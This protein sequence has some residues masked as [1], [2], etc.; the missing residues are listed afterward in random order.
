MGESTANHASTTVKG[1]RGA[2][3]T[4]QAPSPPLKSTGSLTHFFLIFFLSL[5][6]FSKYLSG[7]IFVLGPLE[8]LLPTSCQFLSHPRQ[9][10]V[11]THFNSE[12]CIHFKVLQRH[13]SNDA[14][15]GT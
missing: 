5:K 2:I 4:L 14:K 9:R 11:S 1:S 12:D 15:T 13:V 10:H 8:K 3:L 6:R 7:T